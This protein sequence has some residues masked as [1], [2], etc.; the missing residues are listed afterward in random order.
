VSPDTRLL[1]RPN[2]AV[3][4]RTTPAPVSLALPL[5]AKRSVA[6]RPTSWTVR[7]HSKAKHSLAV[8]L[9]NSHSRALTRPHVCPAPS[10]HSRVC[11]QS[12]AGVPPPWS[13]SLRCGLPPLPKAR[14]S[15]CGLTPSRF[16]DPLASVQPAAPTLA[17][18]EATKGK[19]HRV[20]I[21]GGDGYCGWATALHLSARGYEV[22]ILDSLVRRAMDAQCGFDTLT[23]IASIHT[24]LAAWKVRT[25]ACR[26][27]LGVSVCTVALTPGTQSMTGK[28]IPLYVGD[29]KCVC[30]FASLPLPLSPR[31]LV[32]TSLSPL[33]ITVTT[34]SSAPPS[35]SSAPPPPCTSAS[36]A[37]PLCPY[38]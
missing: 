22:A 6:A 37:G 19:G 18:G 30:S 2:C 31:F 16:P 20:L 29:V 27:L 12:P 24:R 25:H 8:G 21:I 15:R 28:E 10:P 36:S 13:L 32:L 1:F 14:L 26:Q 5:A 3:V 9:Y 11:H 35:L 4:S 17:A 34:S 33:I 7:G 38:V 23:P